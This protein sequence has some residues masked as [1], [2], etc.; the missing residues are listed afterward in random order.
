MPAFNPYR[1]TSQ[2]R[3]PSQPPVVGRQV[4]ASPSPSDYQGQAQGYINQGQGLGYFDAQGSPYINQQLQS[5]ALRSAEAQRQRGSTLARLVGLNPYQQQQAA[6]GQGMQGAH[7]VSNYLND[8]R[9]REL[10]GNRDYIRQ[11]FGGRLANMDARQMAQLQAQLQRQA[12]G[13]G[14]GDFLGQLAGTAAG[15]YLGGPAG[16]ELGGKLFSGGRGGGGGGRSM[17][18]PGW[19]Y[20]YGSG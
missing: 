5:Q 11:L 19:V 17:G 8:A 10:M 3:N 12:Q 7:D 18:S 6:Y 16:A 20:P 15:A 13:G 1:Q 2:F 14:F 9:F 4:S